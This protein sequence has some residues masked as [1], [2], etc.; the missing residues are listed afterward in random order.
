MQP[1]PV[2]GLGDK[3]RQLKSTKPPHPL[4]LP[5]LIPRPPSPPYQCKKT[6]KQKK[7]HVSVCTRS[8][9]YLGPD[10]EGVSVCLSCKQTV[11][12][13]SRSNAPPQRKRHPTRAVNIEIFSRGQRERRR[14]RRKRR[15]KMLLSNTSGL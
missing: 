1:P 2:E 14:R 8:Q 12:R 11:S 9:T 6:I 4:I 7:I 15:K 13:S 3:R 10:E 5:T